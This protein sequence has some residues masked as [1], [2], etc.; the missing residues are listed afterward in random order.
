MF[1]NIPDAYVGL[2]MTATDHVTAAKK[3]Y[4]GNYIS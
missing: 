3:L 2:M 1:W 4:Y